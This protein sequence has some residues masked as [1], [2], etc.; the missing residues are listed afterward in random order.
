MYLVID[1]SEGETVRLYTSDAA[2]AWQ[3]QVQT[4]VAV[5]QLLVVIE[6]ALQKIGKN[7]SEVGGIAVVVGK[8]RFTATRVAVT[9]ANTLAYA[10]NINVV[11][12]AAIDFGTVAEQIKNTPV[13]QYILPTYSAPARIGGA[14]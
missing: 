6:S 7:V 4:G 3:E 12:L 14:K 13:G 10:L 11:G 9:I 5:G 1:S 2:G 8:G